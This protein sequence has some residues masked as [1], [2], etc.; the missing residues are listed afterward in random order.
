MARAHRKF[1]AARR[2]FLH[3]A[4]TRPVRDHDIIAIEDLAQ[5]NMVRHRHLSKA[6]SD[7]GRGEFRRQF[8]YKCA[9]Y[10]RRLIVTGRWYP[11][12]KTCSACGFLLASLPL[13]TR[14]WQ[15]PSCGTRHDRDINAARNI[16]AAGLAVPACGADVSHAGSSR[17]QSALKQEPR[18]VTAGIPVP[19]GGE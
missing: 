8:E 5:K 18:P 17:V 3:R 4:S 1:R 2:D 15:C 13:S 9:W 16:L 12:S 19:Q 14:S 10:G 7:C 6:I 11:S